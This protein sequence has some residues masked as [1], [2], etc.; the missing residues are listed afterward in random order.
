M[1]FTWHEAKRESNLKIHGLDFVDAR[2]VFAGPT[3]T[4]RD[5]RFDYGEERFLTLGLLRG[6]IVSIVHTET[7]R[8]IHIISFRKATKH[9]QAIFFKNL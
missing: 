8:R 1:R 5:D 3:F 4:Y 6:I 2:E 7:P 9:E